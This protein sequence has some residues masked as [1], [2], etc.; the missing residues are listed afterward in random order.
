MLASGPY[1]RRWPAIDSV[2]ESSG[3]Q[4]VETG[5]GALKPLPASQSFQSGLDRQSGAAIAFGVSP[6]RDAS[7][8][9]RGHAQRLMRRA[10]GPASQNRH[11]AE[12]RLCCGGS[13]Q[14]TSTDWLSAPT[15]ERSKAQASW[16]AGSKILTTLSTGTPSKSKPRSTLRPSNS[17]PRRCSCSKPFP[18][19]GAPGQKTLGDMARVRRRIASLNSAKVIEP[20]GIPIATKACSHGRLLPDL[21]LVPDGRRRSRTWL[22]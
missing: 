22:P 13:P 12:M 20:T 10:I 4:Q 6:G 18:L 3:L 5:P 7:L 2:W 1:G 19:V 9:D 16:R 21:W 17:Q 15:G 14:R 8:V 11:G